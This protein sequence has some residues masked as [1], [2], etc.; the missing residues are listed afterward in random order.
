[1]SS[2][3]ENIKT[4]KESND[5]DFIEM[6]KT[7]VG[8]INYKLALLMFVFGFI[9]FSNIFADK[10]VANFDGTIDNDTV[11]TKG[12]LVQLLFY[13]VVLIVIDLFVK[14]NII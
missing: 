14:S 10:V 9:I 8:S 6:A 7:L 11:N 5:G 4:K 12:T 2:N 13:T 3:I 1:M